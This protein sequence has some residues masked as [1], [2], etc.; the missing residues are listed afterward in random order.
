MST[1]ITT[2][3]ALQDIPEFCKE[4]KISRAFFYKLKG[5]GQA[6]KVIKLGARTLITPEARL[7]WR[8]KLNQEAQ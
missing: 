5:L 7:E 2:T 4:N 3:D 1:S 6:P 8:E